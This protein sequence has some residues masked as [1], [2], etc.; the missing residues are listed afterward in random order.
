MVKKESVRADVPR[1]EPKVKQPYVMG[2]K[3]RR[4]KRVV[5]GPY[6]SF[7]GELR[8]SPDPDDEMEGLWHV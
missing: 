7:T 4:V 3:K 6:G 5:K 8:A 2:F 1:K